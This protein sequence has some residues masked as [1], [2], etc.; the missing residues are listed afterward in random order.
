M[1][2]KVRPVYCLGQ[3]EYGLGQEKRCSW[4]RSMSFWPRTKDHP[5]GLRQSNSDSILIKNMFRPPGT[6]FL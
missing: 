4:P 2:R 5:D 1:E 6:R 3:E